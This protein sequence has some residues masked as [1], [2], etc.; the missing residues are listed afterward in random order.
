M[1]GERICMHTSSV[2]L[3]SPAQTSFKCSVNGGRKSKNKSDI[4]VAKVKDFTFG[5]FLESC[6]NEGTEPAISSKAGNLLL[7]N[8]LR[9]KAD[10]STR[11]K[12][13]ALKMAP[14][15]GFSSTRA[16]LLPRTICPAIQL[17]CFR[18]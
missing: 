11:P 2:F 6:W 7:P 13:S 9:T 15:E 4:L 3:Q 8:R 5:W 14:V 10:C 16:P 1:Q 17:R 18:R 12:A